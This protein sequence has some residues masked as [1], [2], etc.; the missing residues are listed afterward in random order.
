MGFRPPL[1]R[2]IPPDANDLLVWSLD[3]ASVPYPSTG[4]YSLPL[5]KGFNPGNIRENRTGIFGQACDF[6]PATSATTGDTAI[7]P[8]STAFT[9]SCW[10]YCRSFPSPSTFVGKTYFL[11]GSGW[12]NPFWAVLMWPLPSGVFS[13]AYSIAGVVT[14]Q[15]GPAS[16]P[17]PLNRWT[18]LAV[19][20]D[21]VRFKQYLNG[22]MIQQ[23]TALNTAIDFGTGGPWCVGGNNLQQTMGHDG[24]IDDVRISNIVRSADYLQ[25]QYK[26]GIGA[27]E[28]PNSAGFIPTDVAGVVLWLRADRTPA[29]VSS[30]VATWYDQSGYQGDALQATSGDRPTYVTV[31]DQT[32]QP[33]LAFDSSVEWLTGTFS[34]PVPALTDLTLFV[35]AQFDD[36]NDR[37]P[38]ALTDSTY[39]SPTG[40]VAKQQSARA[41]TM[42]ITR[43]ASG[44]NQ[45]VTIPTSTTVP[46][47]Y[48]ATSTASVLQG[49]VDGQRQGI[50]SGTTTGLDVIT[51]YVIGAEDNTGTRKMVGRAYE[52]IVYDR[53]LAGS[54]ITSVSNYLLHKYG[55]PP[56]FIPTVLTGCVLWTRSD[57]GIH[58]T[59]GNVDTWADQSGT[60]NDLLQATTAAQ[61]LFNAT[62]AQYNGQAALSFN[63]TQSALR[64]STSLDY[65]LFTIFIACRVTATT[66]YLYSRANGTD[67]LFGS[68]TL[69]AT[70]VT[71]SGVTSSYNNGANWATSA[72]PQTYTRIYD[73]THVGD[74]LRINGMPVSLSS[75]TASDP[76]A[77]STTSTWG[78][79]ANTTFGAPLYS[80]GTVAEVIVY[81][82]VLSPTE[83][84][85]VET[86]LR[87]RY[88]HY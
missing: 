16:D 15:D 56:G 43:H 57:L 17:I 53:I 39:L 9:I 38:L 54:E 18:F 78:L 88:D 59:S 72:V 62:D 80:S 23:S 10:V 47:V 63:G 50:P 70:D 26:C 27:Y 28:L 66:G 76:G 87:I 49:Y 45:T 42:L 83:V 86:Y 34:Y 19:T 29:L 21:G 36:T 85:Q 44:G 4:I 82:R 13:S 55:L 73:G 48:T 1:L 5:V 11:T 67:Y 68:N 77:G 32:G 61:P 3:E 12:N 64:T 51:N 84:D 31:L 81:D 75:G 35:V 30:K 65:G 14:Q 60:G 52:Y 33:H 58:L 20:Y 2:R 37:V 6:T 24:L 25:T 69:P 71:Y 7:V 8:S 40:L 22:N 41:N 79:F 74:V 46:H